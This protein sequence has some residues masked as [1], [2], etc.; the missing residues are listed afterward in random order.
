MGN[1]VCYGGNGFCSYSFSLFVF[2]V[3]ADGSYPRLPLNY[4]PFYCSGDDWYGGSGIRRGLI[5]R[6]VLVGGF[7]GLFCVCSDD[8]YFGFCFVGIFCLWMERPCGVIFDA[9]EESPSLT[10]FTEQWVLFLE[11]MKS[12]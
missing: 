1:D 7:R 10:C 2:F 9:V 3:T 4:H 5:D 11:S 6:V 12:A 8:L